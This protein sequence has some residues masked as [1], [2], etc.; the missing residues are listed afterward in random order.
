MKLQRVL[1]LAL[2]PL[3]YNDQADQNELLPW[4]NIGCGKVLF[5]A[6]WLVYCLFLF[7]NIKGM[8]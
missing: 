6:T 7:I 1:S 5:S 3:Q 4:N 8:K 2:D